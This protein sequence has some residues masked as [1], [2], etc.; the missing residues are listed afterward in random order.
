MFNRLYITFLAVLFTIFVGMT[1][2][3]AQG[4]DDIEVV[5]VVDEEEAGVVEEKVHPDYWHSGFEIS[6]QGGFGIEEAFMFAPT[7][8]GVDWSVSAGW[9]SDKYGFSLQFENGHLWAVDD[10]FEDDEEEDGGKLNPFFEGYHGAV[11]AMFDIYDP[12][13]NFVFRVGL[14]LSVIFGMNC[15]N[16]ETLVM[17]RVEVTTSWLLTDHLRLGVELEVSTIVLLGYVRPSVV[18]TYAF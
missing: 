17:P 11:S 5:A 13:D 2:A 9:H 4:A 10:Y 6:V 7:G 14:G 18:L 16:N 12:H 3:F 15:E 8:I 1:S